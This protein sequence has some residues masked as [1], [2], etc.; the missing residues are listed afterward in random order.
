MNKTQD[1]LL[2][3]PP[4]RSDGHKSDQVVAKHL[5]AITLSVAAAVLG[6]SA[7]CWGGPLYLVTFQTTVNYDP[8]GLHDVSLSGSYLFDQQVPGSVI[9]DGALIVYDSMLSSSIELDG[10]PFAGTGGYLRLDD[11]INLGNGFLRDAYYGV[12]YLDSMFAGHLHLIAAG[13]EFEQV[14]KAPSAITS[15]DLPTSAGDLDGFAPTDE[16]LAFVSFTDPAQNIYASVSAPAQ[17]LSIVQVPE[18]S[19]TLL[20]ALAIGVLVC[21]TRL[22]AA[23]ERSSGGAH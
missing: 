23:Q 19:A 11:N 16:R 2:P 4:A 6:S 12:A 1:Q 9:N 8:A 10:Q 13:L 14:A 7:R 15:F 22:T 5:L 3:F 21:H 18:P 17:N 20:A